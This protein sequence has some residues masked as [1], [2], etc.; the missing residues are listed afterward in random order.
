MVG[1][2]GQAQ[3]VVDEALVEGALHGEEELGRIFHA[4]LE[5]DVAQDV[6]QA[7]RLLEAVGQDKDAVVVA[8]ELEKRIAQEGE[9]LVEKGLQTRIK[10]YARTRRANGMGTY[11]DALEAG[12]RAGEFLAAHQQRLR[13]EQ[14]RAV[15]RSYRLGNGLARETFV[16]NAPD[17]GEY[18]GDVGADHHG[19]LGQEIGERHE[20]IGLLLYVGD[21]ADLRLLLARQLALHLERADGIDLVTEK[22]NAV[23]IFG[24]KG[25]DVQQTAAQ[26]VFAR[27]VHI[28]HATES[29]FF[30]TVCQL[31]QVVTCAAPNDKCVVLHLL[32]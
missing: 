2:Q 23:G 24:G 19:A 8:L 13:V 15:R 10:G 17:S 4:F 25:E 29:Q 20:R 22:V 5:G 27:F 26:G 3:F 32:L 1:E 9:I 30:K 6:A 28:V 12:E 18:E 31:G 7:V 11:V 14:G 21:D 16:V